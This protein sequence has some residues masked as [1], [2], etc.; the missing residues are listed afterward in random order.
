M[1]KKCCDCKSEKELEE[2]SNN[3]SSKDGKQNVCKICQGIRVKKYR[4]KHKEIC[5][6]RG[7]AWRE[8]NRESCVINIRKWHEENKEWERESSKKYREEHK[9]HILKH[10]SEYYWSHH[11]EILKKNPEK[12]QKYKEREDFE[13]KKAEHKEYVIRNKDKI[14]ERTKIYAKQRRKNDL[15]YSILI[16][17]RNRIGRAL[18]YNR[19]ASKS[20]ELLG[21]SIQE[22]RDHIESLFTKDMSWEGFMKGKIHIDHIVPCCAFDLSDP[23]QQKLC[24]NYANTRPMFKLDNLKKVEEDLKLKDYVKNLLI[25]NKNTIVDNNFSL[26]FWFR[27]KIAEIDNNSTFNQE[28]I[29]FDSLDAISTQYLIDNPSQYSPED[30]IVSV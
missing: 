25:S 2:F 18:K 5:A 27:E 15:N 8:R 24:F 22:Y 12:W 19:K 4:E 29:K 10:A 17:L 30:F 7:K 13:E 6:A 23:Y 26:P 3:C 14:N 9:D 16:K 20:V 21:C 28:I 11:E 1:K